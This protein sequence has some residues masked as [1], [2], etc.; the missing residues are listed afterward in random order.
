MTCCRFLHRMMFLAIVV[1][2]LVGCSP[3]QA[4]PAAAPAATAPPTAT[5]SLAAT[6][7][8]APT[9]TSMPTAVPPTSTP[10]VVVQLKQGGVLITPDSA[11]RVERLG[12]IEAIK[13][14]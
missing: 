11:T 5:A 7:T 10:P 14:R 6:T 3:G 4:Q 13:A 8:A 2:L 9:Q 1:T 12:T